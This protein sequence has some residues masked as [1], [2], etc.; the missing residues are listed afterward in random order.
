MK[1][2]HKQ[3]IPPI[4][5]RQLRLFL[6]YLKFYFRRNFHG[7][8]VLRLAPFEPLE[9]LP[10][11]VCMNH[12]SWWDPIM[13]L[14]LSAY[15][16]PDRSHYGP[17]EI[18]GVSKYKFLQKLGFFPI[19]KHSRSG[20]VRFLEVGRAVLSSTRYA[21]WVTPQG[22]FADV[23]LKPVTLR[24]GVGHLAHRAGRFAMLPLAFEYTY[25]NERHP[26]AFACFGRP[27][28]VESGLER[29]PDEWTNLFSAALEETQD[30]L[31]AKTQSRDAAQFEFVFTGRAGV[32][33][34][35]D[36]WRAAKA[37]LQGKQWQPEHGG[38]HDS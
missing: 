11:L 17:I 22:D 6:T 18:Q 31:A 9:S 14:Y 1:S 19:N 29:R 23:R 2:G 37:R 32:G 38:V 8:H 13:A 26:E 34:V 4:A 16:F 10:L 36:L 7:L 21:L 30:A 33:G 15:Y 20:A 12:P 25:W 35:Y 24:A 5:D 28:I 27:L 3:V